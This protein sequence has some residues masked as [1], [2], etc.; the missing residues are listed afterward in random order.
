[1]SNLSIWAQTR[2]KWRHIWCYLLVLSTN[3]TASFGVNIGNE[4]DLKS[5]VSRVTMKSILLSDFAQLYWMAS[6]KSLKSDLIDFLI[7]SLV[8]SIISVHSF[9]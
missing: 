6:S 9:S 3:E 8:T 4:L 7:M 5:L 1:L 2:K